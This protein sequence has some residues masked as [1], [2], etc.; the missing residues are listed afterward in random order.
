MNY[1][2][3]IEQFRKNNQEEVK[4]AEEARLQAEKMKQEKQQDQKKDS[5]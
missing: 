1:Q 2:S 4:R 5:I 3:F